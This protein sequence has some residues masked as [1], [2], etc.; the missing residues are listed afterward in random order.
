ME[1]VELTLPNSVWVELK[2]SNSSMLGLKKHFNSGMLWTHV[3]VS[4]TANR[5]N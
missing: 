2:K 5:V 4:D 1:K 3:R